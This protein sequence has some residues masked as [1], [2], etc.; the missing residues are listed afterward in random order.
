MC[1]EV[2]LSKPLIPAFLL[3]GKKYCVEYEFLHYLC[4]SCGKVGHRSELCRENI[5]TVQITTGNR[6]VSTAVQSTVVN[7]TVTLGE[8]EQND[9]PRKNETV[10]SGLEKPNE[11]EFGPWMLVQGKNKKKNQPMAHKRNDFS[12]Y[13]STHNRFYS[14]SDQGKVEEKDKGKRKISNE[15]PS[16]GHSAAPNV[17]KTSDFKK[18]H[19]STLVSNAS[20]NKS[21]HLQVG[22][23]SKATFRKETSVCQTEHAKNLI[24]MDSFSAPSETMTNS[25]FVPEFSKELDHSKSLP[26]TPSLNVNPSLVPATQTKIKPL[27]KPTPPHSTRN[28]TTGTQ[29]NTATSP[30]PDPPDPSRDGS[31]HFSSGEEWNNTLVRSNGRRTSNHGGGMEHKSSPST[32]RTGTVHVDQ[33]T[34]VPHTGAENVFDVGSQSES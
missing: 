7:G 32:H 15:A 12:K 9:G 25:S 6:N 21:L 20:S 11:N 18:S 19:K 2:D 13:K 29:T 14:L 17:L 26:V 28:T 22:T 24:T 16:M 27:P 31:I 1:V 8:G 3:A 10:V 34:S 5:N 23:S 4:F 33:N 30:A